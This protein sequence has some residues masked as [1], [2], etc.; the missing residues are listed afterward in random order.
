MSSRPL[1]ETESLPN[2]RPLKAVLRLLL[3]ARW[4][5]EKECLPQ[6][7][8]WRWKPHATLG[9]PWAAVYACMG[10]AAWL[11]WRHGGWAQQAMPL[12]LY[13]GL[14]LAAW[15]SW[16]PTF[17]RGQTLHGLLDAL[18]TPTILCMAAF[19]CVLVLVTFTG[20]CCIAYLKAA[21]LKVMPCQLSVCLDLFD[22]YAGQC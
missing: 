12:L 21:A 2:Q 14:L 15:L 22:F 18:G 4:E 5:V 16:P 9:G 7:T 3:S 20:L 10:A 8:A 17:R 6:Q 13:T 11:V 19:Q 1:Q